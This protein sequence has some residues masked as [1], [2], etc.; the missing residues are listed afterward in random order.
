ME[1]SPTREAS[2]LTVDDDKD[3]KNLDDDKD[4]KTVDDDKD[5]KTK[6][7]TAYY[8]PKVYENKGQILIYT[9]SV[10]ILHLPTDE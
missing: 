3:I 5:I 10:F 7:D 2:P 9:P 8:V 6:C 4:I 1:G